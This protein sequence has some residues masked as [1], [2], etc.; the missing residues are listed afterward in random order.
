MES[1][2]IHRRELANLTSSFAKSAAVLSNCEEHNT[3]SRALS[4]LA[5]VEEKVE[6]LYNYQANS[7]F[8]ILCELLKDYVAL[9]GAIK[10]SC[11]FAQQQ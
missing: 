7:D 5:E 9:I 10:V 8:S 6:N 1:L 2:V 3:L 4:Q 11:S